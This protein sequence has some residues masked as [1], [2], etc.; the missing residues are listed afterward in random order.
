M[1]LLL[2][3]IATHPHLALLVVFGVALAESLAL[4]GT[5]VPAGVVMFSAGALIGAGSLDMWTT[6]AVAALGAVSGDALSYERGRLGNDRLRGWPPFAR[7]AP[8]MARG[9]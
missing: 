5:L 2:T 1:H 7:Y 3:H 6:L 9:E 4:I 8:L